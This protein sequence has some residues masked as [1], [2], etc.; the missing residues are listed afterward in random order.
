MIDDHD[1]SVLPISSLGFDYPVTTG[2]VSTGIER[3][4]AML[5]GKGY[6]SGSSVLVSGTAGTG[7]SSLAAA[8]ADAAACRRGERCLYVAFEEAPAQITRNMA[9]VGF[10]LDQ[11]TKKG[12]LR[13]HAV[14]SKPCGLEQHLGS[15]IKFTNE[16]QP[17]AVVIDPV[18]NLSA[19]GS[20]EEI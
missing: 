9:S 13:F 15:I 14:R 17:T 19:V 6:Y 20:T 3:L 7:K 18:T 12:F 16:F 10:D 1:L 4:D 8:F 2:R 5:G 11:W